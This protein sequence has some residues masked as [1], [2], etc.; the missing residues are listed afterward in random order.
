MPPRTLTAACLAIALTGCGSSHAPAPDAADT[1]STDDA[2]DGRED[3]DATSDTGTDAPGADG[4]ADDGPCMP[5]LPRCQGD[6]GYQMCQQDGTWGPSSSCAGYSMNGTTSYCAELP[7]AG[8]GAWGTCVDPACWYWLGR[9][10]L[11]GAAQVGICQADGTIDACNAGGTL[12]PAT[13]DGVCTTVT[14]LDGRA[15]GYCAPACEDGAR[16]C[17][18]GPFYRTCAQGRWGAVPATCAGVCN[19]VATGARP[20]VRCGGACDPDTSRC[21]ADLGAV[22]RCGADGA[23]TLDRTCL[24]G[25]CRPGGAQAECETECVPGA[26]ACAFDGAPAERACDPTGLWTAERP[27]PDATSCRVAGDVALGCVACAS[28][29]NA[30]AAADSRCAAGGAQT[31]GAD[32]GW[33]AATPCPAAQSCVSISRGASSL[34]ACAAP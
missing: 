32:G 22:E 4:Y 8:G 16:E 20:D 10:A 17:L 9:G 18:G 1:P 13:C 2:R 34:A 31:C 11:G 6:F 29:G 28:G 7:M 15:V 23:W 33:Q 19:P 30:Y 24:L 25:R 27:C 5:G 12:A 3:T 14:T 26:H 21:S